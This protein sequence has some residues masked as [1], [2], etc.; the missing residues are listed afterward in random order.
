[1][2]LQSRGEFEILAILDSVA[3]F[4][5]V[6]DLDDLLV[7]KLFFKAFT[8]RLSLLL[9]LASEQHHSGLFSSLPP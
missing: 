3:L 6:N 4:S 5:S 1:M 9:P 2:A 7:N 8:R